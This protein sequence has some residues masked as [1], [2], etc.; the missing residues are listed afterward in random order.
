MRISHYMTVSYQFHL[1]S[2]SY[3]IR[4]SVFVIFREDEITMRYFVKIIGKRGRFEKRGA[5]EEGPLVTFSVIFDRVPLPQDGAVPPVGPGALSPRGLLG[6]ARC[7][8][9]VTLIDRYRV[10]NE[11]RSSLPPSPSP[12]GLRPFLLERAL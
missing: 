6:A 7:G 9:A 8:R 4:R 1:R 5:P 10:T 11:I 3:G 12:P 2:V